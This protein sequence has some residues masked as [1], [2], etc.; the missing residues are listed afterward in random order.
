MA[1]K[2]ERGLDISGGIFFSHGIM[3]VRIPCPPPHQILYCVYHKNRGWGIT[4]LSASSF[5]FKFSKIYFVFTLL[6]TEKYILLI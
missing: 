3:N 4:I 6:N 1:I 2:L 5:V